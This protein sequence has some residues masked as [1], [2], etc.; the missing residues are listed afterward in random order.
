[1]GRRKTRNGMWCNRSSGNGPVQTSWNST[2][3]ADRGHAESEG[4]E[5]VQPTQQGAH[6]H[7]TESHRK[8]ARTY[9]NSTSHG[10]PG[11]VNSILGIIFSLNISFSTEIILFYIW[12]KL[13]SMTLHDVWKISACF[14]KA[15]ADAWRD[16]DC[17][18]QA[19]KTAA[20]EKSSTSDSFFLYCPLIK[21]GSESGMK[22]D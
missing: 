1:M 13:Q 11:Q 8:E 14:L 21:L 9:L 10:T 16:W 20:E 3:I 19:A 2:I 5:P 7:T 18:K 4:P 6:H 15:L 17:C 22:L 12:R